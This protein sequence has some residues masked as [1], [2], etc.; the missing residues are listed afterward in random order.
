MSLSVVEMSD[1]KASGGFKCSHGGG[2]LGGT[3]DALCPSVASL[4]ELA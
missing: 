2:V 1:P 4:G 3:A